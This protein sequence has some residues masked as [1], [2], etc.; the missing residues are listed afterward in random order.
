MGCLQ[1]F[2]ILLMMHF[3]RFFASLGLL[4]LFYILI[5]GVY[6]LLKQKEVCII[7]DV[8][9]FK[10]VL[11]FIGFFIIESTSD[12][13]FTHNRGMYMLIMLTLVLKDLQ[14]RRNDVK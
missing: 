10:L 14:T 2:L 5:F 6:G 7:G 12:T 4:E 11:L 9:G 3:I 13:T 8:Y 1:M